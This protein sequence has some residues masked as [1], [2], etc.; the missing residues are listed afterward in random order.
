MAKAGRKI[1][2]FEI[3]AAR[4]ARGKEVF[5]EPPEAIANRPSPASAAPRPLVGG[6]ATAHEISF[7]RDGAF[8]IFV[9]I[10]VF[11]GSAY[12]LGY[13]SGQREARQRPAAIGSGLERRDDVDVWQG[14]EGRPI[15]SSLALS[16]EEFTLKLRAIDR[17]SESELAKLRAE[18]AYLQ[19]LPLLKEEK[20]EAYIFEK[21]DVCTL[22]VGIFAKRD[23]P[24]L[25][26]LQEYFARHRG[27]PTSR[28]LQ[29]YAG[30]SATQTNLLGTL[31]P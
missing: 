10:L 23:D 29:P 30:C 7:S 28:S 1:E 21:G 27:P 11:V 12:L 26:R 31:M 5:S 15:V 3:L 24:R 25:A 18:R 20:L 8:V 13:Q 9:A 19:A 17:K 2:L 22:A 6:Y 16:G 4:K 14:I